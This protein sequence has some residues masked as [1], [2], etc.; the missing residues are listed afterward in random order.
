[1][2]RVLDQN[3]PAVAAPVLPHPQIIKSASREIELKFLVAEAGFKAT[4]Q[5]ALL[6]GNGRLAPAKRMLTV[7]FD[8]EQGDLHQAKIALRM[9]AQRRGYIMALK[10]TDDSFSGMFERGEIEIST[11]LDVPDTALLGPEIATSLAQLT[12]GRALLP[13]FATDIRRAVHVLR[14]ETS[15]IEI[16]FDSGAIIAGDAKMPVREIELELKSGDPADLYR[17]GISLAENFPV[18]LGTLSKAGRGALLAAGAAPA[19][20]RALSPLA[21]T[22][23]VDEAISALISHCL[24][25]FTGNWPAFEA[26]DSVAAIHQMRV[27]MRRLRAMLGLFNRAFPCAEFSAFR[28]AAKGIA[29]AMG[30]ARNLDVFIALVKSGPLAAFAGEAGFAGIL[31][32]CGHRR[33]AAYEAVKECLADPGTTRFVLSLQAFTARRGWRNALSGDALARLTAPAADFAAANLARLHNR[34]MKRGKNFF[35]L[36]PHE[37]HEVRIELKKLRYAADAFAGLF[38]AR[39][40]VR[41]YIRAAAA[42]QDQLGLFNDFHT[43]AELVNSL[44]A[45]DSRAA[46]IILGWC[47]RGAAGQDETLRE[48]WKTFRKSKL[49][50]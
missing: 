48:A 27:A 37:R 22:V 3:I 35:S 34:L 1:M 36:P 16:A 6:G 9:R 4:R 11:P 17:L 30:E 23:L 2:R 14:T 5:S 46:G 20:V 44:A 26:G 47:A 41:D 15:V 43:A 31:A 18:R 19:P 13:V 8:T 40:Q 32:E 25:Q 10:W 38:A 24:A 49:F 28:E 39:K 12:K 33:D 29:T 50:C 42:L 45:A 21:G 7:Y